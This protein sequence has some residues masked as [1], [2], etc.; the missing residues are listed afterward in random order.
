[1]L[2]GSGRGGHAGGD[3]SITVC[4]DD[5][6]NIFSFAQSSKDNFG[7]FM[8]MFPGAQMIK[9]ETN[10][11]SSQNI[12]AA[13]RRVIEDGLNPHRIPKNCVSSR[14]TG[15]KVPGEGFSGLTSFQV[16][17]CVCGSPEQEVEALCTYLCEKMRA[18]ARMSSY[19]LLFRCTSHPT[20]PPVTALSS[21]DV[22]GL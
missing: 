7:Q 1:M 15:S 14:G 22:D 4:G 6:Q 19:A 20:A 17:I 12:V 3:A 5:D 9:L 2:C 11:R 21:E 13:C 18:G 16:G 8:R 10:F